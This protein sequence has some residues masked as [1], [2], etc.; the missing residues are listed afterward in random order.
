MPIVL[1]SAVRIIMTLLLWFFLSS[2]LFAQTSANGPHIRVDLITE[3]EQLVAGT[4]WVRIH[5]QSED[6]WHTY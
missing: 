5:F 4:N 2:T 3:H 1:T 6:E